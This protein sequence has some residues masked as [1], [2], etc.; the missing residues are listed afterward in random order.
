M[1]RRIKP[2][3]YSEGD[4]IYFNIDGK[5]KG[6]G[7]IRGCAGEYPTI[8]TQWIVESEKPHPY[9]TEAY[10]YSCISC[11]D[12]QIGEKSFDLKDNPILDKEEPTNDADVKQESKI[13]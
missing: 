3:K 1:S 7:Y 6:W 11:F 13:K 5:T 4:K 9:D 8:G 12:V 10:P 2:R